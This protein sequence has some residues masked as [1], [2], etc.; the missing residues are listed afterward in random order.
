MSVSRVS[1]IAWARRVKVK[2]VILLKK[3]LAV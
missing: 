3:G 1:G 2:K